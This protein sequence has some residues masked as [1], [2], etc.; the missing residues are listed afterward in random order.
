MDKET[1]VN[2]QPEKG[3]NPPIEW[4]EKELSNC[5]REISRLDLEN[6]QLKELVVFLA[7][8]VKDREDTLTYLHSL[9]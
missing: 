5:R 1:C 9:D 4:Y 2:A 8:K 7:L 6:R 3:E